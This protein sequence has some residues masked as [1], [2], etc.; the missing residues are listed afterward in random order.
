MTQK[1]MK[2]LHE[3]LTKHAQ[4]LPAKNYK[5]LMK[6]IKQ[7]LWDK[8]PGKEFLDLTPKAASINFSTK[9]KVG[10]M[11]FIKIKS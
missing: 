9:G 3:N 4:D 5:M 6:E 1:K 7:N 11:N 2:Y 10:K 8:G